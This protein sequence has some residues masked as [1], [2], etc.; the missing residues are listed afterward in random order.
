MAGAKDNYRVDVGTGDV[1]DLEGE[2]IGNLN[3]Y[4]K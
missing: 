3:D 4:F 1:L 2:S